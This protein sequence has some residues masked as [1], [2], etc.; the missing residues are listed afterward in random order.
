M[1][2]GKC[3]FFKPHKEI[4]ISGTCTN[5]ESVNIALLMFT[6]ESCKEFKEIVKNG[7]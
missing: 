7:Q 2:C 3:S 4:E 5:K 6:T 1:I